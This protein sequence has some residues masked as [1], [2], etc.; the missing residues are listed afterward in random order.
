ML[1]K[2]IVWTKKFDDVHKFAES[3]AIVAKEMS[4]DKVVSFL[5]GL[6][7]KYV[8]LHTYDTNVDPRIYIPSNNYHANAQLWNNENILIVLEEFQRVLKLDEGFKKFMGLFENNNL[9]HINN[10]FTTGKENKYVNGGLISST[11]IDKAVSYSRTIMRG[12][13]DELEKLGYFNNYKILFIEGKGFI[14]SYNG[15]SAHTF[16]WFRGLESRI[17]NYGYQDCAKLISTF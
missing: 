1:E 17:S 11:Q 13:Y 5:K 14:K 3:L 16:Y 6:I 2:S 8:A 4:P 9:C 12:L 15:S 10:Y 7:K